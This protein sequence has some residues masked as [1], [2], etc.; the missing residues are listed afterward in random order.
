MRRKRRRRVRISKNGEGKLKL[1]MAGWLLVL[2][3][4][5]NFGVGEERNLL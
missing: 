4:F 3:L 2:S 1:A 5:S